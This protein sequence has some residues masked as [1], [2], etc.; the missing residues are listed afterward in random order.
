MKA[1]A[2][3]R[4]APSCAA[5]IR[6]IRALGDPRS[7]AGMARY[8][9]RPRKA[10]GLSAARIRALARDLGKNHELAQELWAT[11]IREAMHVATLIEEPER[12]TA[13][14]MERWARGFDSWD[15]VDGCCCHLLVFTPHAWD[16]AVAWSGRDAMFVKRAGFALMAYLAVHDQ[17]APERCFERLL[18]LIRRASVDPRDLV[19][20]AVNWALRQIGKRSPRL[21][22]RAIETAEH[23]RRLDSPAA[24]WIAADALR[25]LRSAAVQQR[26]RARAQPARY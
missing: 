24:R 25:E 16:K 18:P 13:A 9:I 19:K 17:Q 5:V 2:A 7:V 11:G 8:G 15:A 1:A 23:I 21:N 20:K 12:V 26:L 6:R 22:R 3:A 4:G 14:Q 10:Y